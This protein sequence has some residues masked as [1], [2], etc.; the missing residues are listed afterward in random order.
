MDVYRVEGPQLR[1]LITALTACPTQTHSLSVGVDGQ[2]V[3]FKIDAS[4]W[5]AP[6]G[7]RQP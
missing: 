6:M 2:S 7:T 5:S 3:T 4:V 1:E